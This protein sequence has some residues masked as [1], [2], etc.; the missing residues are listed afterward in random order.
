MKAKIQQKRYNIENKEQGDTAPTAF[1]ILFINGP[2]Y[3]RMYAI[4][5]VVPSCYIS[6][7][8]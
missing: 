7:Q 4:K 3:S 6:E 8:F 2:T 1:T 5:V